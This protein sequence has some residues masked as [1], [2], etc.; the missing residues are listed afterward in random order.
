MSRSRVQLWFSLFALVGAIA[1]LGWVRPR[2]ARDHGRTRLTYDIY[3][4]PSPRA[5]VALSLGY[6]SALADLLFSHVLVESGLH[7]ADRRRFQTVAL[8]LRAIN[9]LDPKFATP[10]HFAD[11][12]ITLQAGKPSL[13]DYRAARSILERGMAELPYDTQL[14]LTAGEFMAYLAA[15]HVEA[16]AGQAVAREWRLEGARRLAR[17]CEIIGSNEAIPYHCVTAARLFSEA[18]ERQALQSFAERVLAVSDDPAIHEQ[19]WASL[20]RARDMTAVER[21]KQHR[22]RLDRIQGEQ[23]PG[24]SK[25]GFLLLGPSFSPTECFGERSQTARC[26]TSFR[27]WHARLDA[28]QSG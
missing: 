5:L 27:D 25:D 7:I 10:Y 26:A 13:E 14:W 12:L 28:E 22:E 3:V 21:M 23:M 2:L 4:L 8:Y 9:E 11:T 6:R 1:V 16:L 24:L 18:G 17:T 15:P 20:A 19:I